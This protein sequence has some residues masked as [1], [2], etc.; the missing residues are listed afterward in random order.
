[1]GENEPLKEGDM[2][3]AGGL[4]GIRFTEGCSYGCAELYIE[5]DINFHFVAKFDRVW[6]GDL[7]MV[8]KEALEIS[9]RDRK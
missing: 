8:T 5:D 3:V 4:F 6:L 7:L 1:M 9:K 2:D